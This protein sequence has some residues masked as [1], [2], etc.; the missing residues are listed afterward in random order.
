MVTVAGSDISLEIDGNGAW[1]RLKGGDQAI[2][3]PG[4]ALRL[5]LAGRPASV[6]AI[7]Q[8]DGRLTLALEGHD[9]AGVLRLRPRA[10]AIGCAIA[11]QDGQEV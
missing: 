3:L 9:C 11:I 6:R 1:R 10:D 5:R 2:P 7:H 4:F 8:V